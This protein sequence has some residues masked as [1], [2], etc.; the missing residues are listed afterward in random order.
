VFFTAIVTPDD[1]AYVVTFPDAPGC[2]TQADSAGDVLPIATE[3]LAGWL[4]ASLEAGD[5]LVGPGR[6]RRAP[7]GARTILV[8]VTIAIGRAR[9]AGESV[10][11]TLG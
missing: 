10:Q 3:A 9:G 1:G 8:P 4:E 2:V 6:S 5:L 11:L 7:R